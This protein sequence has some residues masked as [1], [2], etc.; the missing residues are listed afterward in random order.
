MRPVLFPKN[1][2]RMNKKMIFTALFALVAI[3]AYGQADSTKVDTTKVDSTKV[4]S[5]KVKKGDLISLRGTVADGFTKAAIPEVTVTLMREDSTVV[6]KMQVWKMSHYSGAGRSV[7]TTNYSFAISRQPAKYILKMEHPNYETAFADFE[8]K[9][10]GRRSTDID[11]PKV[12]LKKS[13]KASHFEGGS[14]GEVEV[15]ATKIKMVWKGDTL[16]YN[17]DAFNVPEGSM[18]DGLIKQLPGVELKDNGEI[19]VNG[20]KIQNLTLNGADFFKGKNKIMLENLPYFTVKNI[21][22]YNKQT[23]LNKY[24]GI[25]D[26]NKKEYTMDVVLKREYSIGGSANVEAGGG[27]SDGGDWRYKLKGFGLRFSDR[28]RA[29]AFGGL[30]NINES[31]HYSDWRGEYN[32]RTSQTGDNHFKQVG[33]QFVYQAPE[34][35]LTNST[36]VN[37][38]WSNDF[39][40][41]R[42]QSET[43][44][45]E[46]STFGKSEGTSRRKPSSFELKNE[47]RSTGKFRFHTNVSLNYNHSSRESEEWSLSTSDALFQ[48][49]INS[50]WSRSRSKTENFR[51]NADGDLTYRLPSGDY[52]S[53]D[54]DGSFTRYK[55]PEESSLNHYVYHQLGTRDIRDRRT[56]SPSHAYNYQGQ[57]SYHYQLTKKISISPS[58]A[59][60]KNSDKSDIHEYLRDSIDYIFDALN[61]YEQHTQTLGWQPGVNFRCHNN[62]EKLYYSF[63]AGFQLNF[64][65]EKMD[66]TSEP[67]TTSLTRHYTQ[68]SPTVYFGLGSRDGKHYISARY[69]VW[70]STPSVTHLIDRPITSDPLNIFL[71]NPDL[72]QS[73]QHSWNTEYTLR[74]DSIS[75]TIRFSLNG[76]LTQN[77]ESYGYTYDPTTGV[78][79]YRPENISGGNWNVSSSVNWSRALDKK[80]TWFIGNDLSYRYTKSTSHT[81]TTNGSEAELSR[82]GTSL[83]SYSPN[84]RFQ[85]SK[86]SLSAVGNVTYRHIHRNITFGEQPT[87]VWDF[88]YGMN[89]TYK[90]PWNFTFETDLSMHSRRGY[91]DEEMNDNRLYW[92][93]TLTKSIKQGRWVFKLRGYDL[94]RQVSNVQYYISSQGRTEWWTNSMRRYALLTVSYRFSQ[95]PKK[96]KEE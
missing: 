69:Y 32:D 33:G 76:S 28:T 35:K 83:V 20:K 77:T 84:V 82:V 63:S 9:R 75:Q 18:L 23:E 87:D 71:G 45:N 24:L 26:E 94:L 27:P 7:T 70:S 50:T 54:F 5:P 67:L 44:M 14:V 66:Y 37:A 1:N 81:N 95:K 65:R 62:N 85:K 39:T 38:T 55:T 49:S 79:T 73:H 47:F 60:R 31:M 74:N 61:S 90:L 89:G 78:R 72:K 17:A 8:M 11:G 15:K 41:S 43:F 13:A 40:E 19:F 12:Y 36:E 46:I 25:D 68:F 3:A 91:T 58:I 53:F 21:K 59:F 6:S 88:S 57:L 29:V 80:K 16:V 30:N 96:E 86:L 10:V 4:E 51:G 34:D 56:N 52:I 42:R 48:D 92:D 22:V 2:D 64:L 93:A